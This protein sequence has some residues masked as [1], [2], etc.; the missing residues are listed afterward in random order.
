MVLVVFKEVMISFGLLWSISGGGPAFARGR[1]PPSDWPCQG[2]ALGKWK[3]GRH[4]GTCR[5]EGLVGVS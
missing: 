4:V 1:H 2:Q 3:S 5:P